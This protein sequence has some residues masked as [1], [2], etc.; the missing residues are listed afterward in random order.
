MFFKF[1]IIFF[2]LQK[3]LFSCCI[4]R[5]GEQCNLFLPDTVY[6]DP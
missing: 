4:L 1:F 5:P 3:R 6:D 2:C